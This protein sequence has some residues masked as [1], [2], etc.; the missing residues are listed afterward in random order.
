M[1]YPFFTAS[2]QG[3]KGEWPYYE[4]ELPQ[5]VT[6]Q[7]LSKYKGTGRTLCLQRS[8]R[9]ALDYLTTRLTYWQVP[10]LKL[11]MCVAHL[12]SPLAGMYWAVYQKV[13]SSLG[14]TLMLV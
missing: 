8:L 5:S 7:L 6:E 4:R 10:S 14:S 2:A 9:R 13:Q 12:K 11:L 3:M 1:E